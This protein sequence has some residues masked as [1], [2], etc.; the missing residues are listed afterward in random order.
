MKHISDCLL[1]AGA[2][3]VSAGA[4]MAWEPAGLLVWG[5][6]LVAAGLQMARAD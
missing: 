6:M 1:I 5:A 2:V 4:W 3:S